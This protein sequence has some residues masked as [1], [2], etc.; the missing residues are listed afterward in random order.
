[1]TASETVREVILSFTA[2]S[3]V[4]ELDGRPVACL[5]P[6]PTPPDEP[7]EWTPTKN[8][9]RFYLIDKE[10]AHSLTAE[11][12]S[13]LEMLTTQMRV[14]VNKVAPLPMEA[15]RKLHQELLAKAANTPPSP[16]AS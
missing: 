13:E 14:Y 5:I 4:F 12:T 7:E 1:N 9:R 11:E 15:A 16:S 6:P 3:T 8:A 2:A 10:I